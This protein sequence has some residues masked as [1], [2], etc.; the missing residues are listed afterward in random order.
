MWTQLLGVLAAAAYSVVVTYVLLRVLKAT[1]GL[2]VDSEVEY[3]G[4]DGA[5]HGES[6]YTIGSGSARWEEPVPA[7][8]D[9]PM[10]ISAE[11]ALAPVA[12][13]S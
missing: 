5:L 11:P 9:E 2:R 4:L 10:P 3:N 12:V 13:R 6:G 8:V 7:P 1:V